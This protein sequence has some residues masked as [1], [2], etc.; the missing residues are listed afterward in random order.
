MA[1]HGARPARRGWQWLLLI[2]ILAPLPVG[3]Y[4]RLEPRLWGIPFFY[5]YQVGC[6]F[7]ATAV[8]VLVYQLSRRGR[9]R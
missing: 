4:D 3:L 1:E 8:T 6:A 9:R 2:P 5:W 7:L